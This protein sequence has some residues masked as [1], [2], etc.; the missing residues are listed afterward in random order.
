MVEGLLLTTATVIATGALVALARRLIP[1]DTKQEHH[2]VLIAIHQMVGMLYTILLA[3][4][5]IIVWEAADQADD[6]SQAEA[7]KLS[8]IYFTARGMPEP[9]QGELKDLASSYAAVVVD[10]EWPLMREGKTSAEARSLV[11]QMRVTAHSLRPTTPR[12]E[13]LMTQTLDAINELVDARRE[14]TS[15]VE[16]SVPPV[17][18][19]GL[20]GG[21]VITVGFTFF[22]DYTR[23]LPHFL[24]TST[25]SG[26]VAFIL[27][28][29]WEMSYPF[30]GPTGVGPDAFAHVLDRFREFP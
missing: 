8:Q 29:T 23:Y 19:A 13:I 14:R 20:L 5:V 27:W 4:V 22:Y 2:D 25:F 30:D 15:A 16:P 9:Q 6:D 21:T 12:D 18:W 7:N 11:G 28:L 3:F 17:M 26:L 24:M 10:K 1:G